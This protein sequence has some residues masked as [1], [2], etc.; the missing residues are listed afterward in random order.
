MHTIQGYTGNRNSF[1]RFGFGTVSQYAVG[2]LG[3]HNGTLNLERNTS[4]LVLTT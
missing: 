2:H 3:L 1:A 4:M